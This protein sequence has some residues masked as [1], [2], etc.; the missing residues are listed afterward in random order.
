MN[1]SFDAVT[2]VNLMESGDECNLR[3]ID[4][5][6][7]GCTFTKLEAWKLTQ[8]SKCVFLDADTLVCLGLNHR[9]LG[10][11][12]M[13]LTHYTIVTQVVAPSD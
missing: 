10:D 1:A 9:P 8:Y 5:P 7:L 12:H 2:V 6:D 11:T 4:R 3:L 13:I